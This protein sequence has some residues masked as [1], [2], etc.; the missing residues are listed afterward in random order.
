MVV[1]RPGSRRVNQS[2]IVTLLTSGTTVITAAAT[3][4]SEVTA[5]VTA[6]CDHPGLRAP[7]GASTLTLNSVSSAGVD[8]A[9]VES[10]GNQILSVSVDDERFDVEYADSLL[11][12]TS[13]EAV[14]RGT[15]RMTLET[16]CDDG[17]T[18]SY[19]ITV[20]VIQTLP[21]L[22]VRQSQRFNLV[23]P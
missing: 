11:T 6:E 15:Y 5:Q 21:R 3:D 10:Y 12:L 20:R 13:R 16:V 17:R 18:Y 7:L 4:G 23:L 22:T 1:Q 14:A 8:V 9:L 19:P 2:G